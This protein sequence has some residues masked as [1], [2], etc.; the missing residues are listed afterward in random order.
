MT[1]AQI[2]LLTNGN[3]RLSVDEKIYE[4]VKYLRFKNN[5]GSNVEEEVWI[6]IPVS[7][8]YGFGTVTM[9]SK[10]KLYPKGKV[11]EGVVITPYPGGVDE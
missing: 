9:E 1:A 8:S 11:A 6:Y 10:V 2:S 4:G 5:G 7:A 3:I